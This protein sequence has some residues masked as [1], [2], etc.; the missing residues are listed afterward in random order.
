MSHD[1][2]EM[3]ESPADRRMCYCGCWEEEH[4]ADGTCKYCFEDDCA[5]FE[6]DE[7]GTI[8]AL[9]EPDPDVPL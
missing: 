3:P 9:C 6:Y 4:R 2:E 7:E 1:E 5:G 8:M